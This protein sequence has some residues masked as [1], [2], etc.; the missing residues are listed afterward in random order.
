MAKRS[1]KKEY[2]TFNS[3]M[4]TER[5]VCPVHRTYDLQSDKQHK[6]RENKGKQK[7]KRQSTIQRRSKNTV[8]DNKEI[9]KCH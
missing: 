5:E 8:H 9:T 3:R 6:K 1:L 2:P 4:K 7:K